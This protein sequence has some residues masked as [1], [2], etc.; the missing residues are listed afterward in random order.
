MLLES[1]V[2]KDELKYLEENK[3]QIYNHFQLNSDKLKKINKTFC[4]LP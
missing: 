4:D 2:L 1:I 3:S